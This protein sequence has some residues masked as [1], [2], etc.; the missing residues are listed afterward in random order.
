MKIVSVIQSFINH[1]SHREG[2]SL[3]LRSQGQYPVKNYDD[4]QN[5]LE[6][7]RIIDAYTMTS[8][9][10]LVTLWQQVRFLDKVEINGAL[11][12]CG[13]WRG[14][15]SAMMAL[16][17]KVSGKPKRTIH[18]FDSFEGL[19]EPISQ[20]DGIMATS[21]AKDN[22]RGKLKAIGKCVGSLEDNQEVMEQIAYYPKS[23]IQYHKG[24]FQNT[25]SHDA[26][27]IGP[28]AL[29]RLD[30]DWYE[31]TKICLDN[32]FPSVVTGGI[33]VLDDYGKWEGCRHATDEYFATHGLKYLLHHIDSSARYFIK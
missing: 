19:P 31:S 17:H 29:L 14:G 10:R 23:L 12:E 5:A 1:R 32:L 20:K 27:S 21:Y 30:G 13:T 4:E 3:R 28:I 25:I 18:L 22:A 6:A 7:L 24:W 2:Q 8:Y 26:S 33:V 9:E 16:A 11:V 15:C